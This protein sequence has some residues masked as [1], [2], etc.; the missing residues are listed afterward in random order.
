MAGQGSARV[1]LKEI[2]LSQVRN[3]QQAPQGVPAAVV[4]PARKGPAFVPRTFANMQQFEEVFGSLN[5]RGRLTNSNLYGPLA[6]NEW[7][8]SAQAGTYLRVL[9]VGDGN[10]ST[11]GGRVQDAGFIVGEK[12]VHVSEDGTLGKLS[13]N[14]FANIGENPV[15]GRTH[16]LGCFMKDAPGSSY[17]KDSG[18]ETQDAQASFVIDFNAK[19]NNT[20]PA[21]GSTITI[22]SLTNNQ[23][24][25]VEEGQTLVYGFNTTGA[26]AGSDHVVNTTVQDDSVKVAV[27]L[28]RLINSNHNTLA[29]VVVIQADGQDTAKISIKQDVA[30]ESGN[31]LITS[32]LVSNNLGDFEISGQEVITNSVNDASIRLKGG[33]VDSGSI[34]ISADVDEGNAVNN[35]NIKSNDTLILSAL[36]D[37]G[38]L[39]SGVTITFLNDDDFN[40]LDIEGVSPIPEDVF[41]KDDNDISLNVKIGENAADTVEGRKETLL[42]LATAINNETSTQ[43]SGLLSAVV[44][45]DGLTLTITQV[46]PGNVNNNPDLE[47]T[48]TFIFTANSFKLNDAKATGAE[49]NSG[50]FEG[51]TDGNASV[52]IVFSS[53]PVIGDNFTL[54]AKDD[55]SEKFEFIADANG[56]DNGVDGKGNSLDAI[57]V[58]LADTLAGTIANLQSA[59]VGA[60]S[61]S[62]V[63]DLFSV[64]DDGNSLTI[65]QTASGLGGNTELIF[66]LNEVVSAVAGGVTITGNFGNKETRFNGGGGS[67]SPIIRGVLMTP[68]GVRA[69]LSSDDNSTEPAENLF[70]AQELD[71]LSGDVAGLI[72]NQYSF[73]LFLNG[74]AGKRSISCSFDPDSSSYISK[75]LNT[76]PTKIEEEGHCLYAWWDIHSSVATPS[77]QGLTHLG[78]PLEATA[79]DNHIA[80]CVTGSEAVGKDYESFNARYQTART[81]W[82]MSQD[83]GGTQ[84]KLF[85]LHSLDDGEISNGM[86]RLLMSNL[87]YESDVVYGRFD[88][89]LE[90][91]STSP[92][93]GD[94]IVGW[95]NLS[96]DPD[97]RNYIARVIGD[98]YT[99]YNFDLEE[100]KQRL[101]VEGNYPIRNNFVRIELSDDLLS[102]NVPVDAL[103]TGFLGHRYLNTSIPGNFVDGKVFDDT[104]AISTAVVS[105]VKFVK[106]I[107]RKINNST[108]EASSDLAWGVKLAKKENDDDSLKELSE[109][110]NDDSIVSYTKYFPHFGDVFIEDDGSTADFQNGRFSLEKIQ[111]P[112]SGLSGDVLSSWDNA[113]YRRDGS[114]KGDQGRFVKISKDATGKNVRF[115]KFRCLFQGGF[116]GVNIF[117]KEKAEFTG[118]ASLREGGDETGTNKYTGPTVMAYRRACDVLTDKSAVEFQVLALPGQRASVVTDYALSACE[119]RFDA[120]Y[121][122]DIVE[123]DASLNVI[124]SNSIK[125]HVRNTVLE[126][127][128]RG[129]DSSFGAAYFPDVMVR[130]PSDGA[131]VSVPPSVGM[132][133]VLSRNDQISAPWFAPAGLN[134][135][136]LN[137]TGVKVQMNRDL[138]DELYDADINPIYEPA[139]RAGEVYAFGQKTLMQDSSALDRINVR[140]LLI[141][142]RRKVKR[143]GESLLFE[144]NRASTLARFSALVEPIMADVQSRQGVARYKVQID[145]STTTQNDIENNTIRGKIYLQPLKSIEFISLDFVVANTIE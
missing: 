105:P 53:L 18:V 77:Q 89:T 134:R 70:V 111:I 66:N 7:M 24:N 13:D 8:R 125:P 139:G 40:A 93:K 17:L 34:A 101:Q 67:A 37:D 106:S 92:Q 22:T 21:N 27:E 140:R 51:G 74:H 131:S 25:P 119:E 45:E 97:D 120:L 123:K 35:L 71:N 49:V 110:V 59:I 62:A 127:S 115:L 44:S 55:T 5:T 133:G 1:T 96:L 86:Y 103:P 58:E 9:G 85:R 99:Y 23:L 28:A 91:L 12:Q 11:G 143:I 61:G 38:D 41:F 47:A 87:R 63:K 56:V 121:L 69:T 54:V 81:P 108:N 138:L 135:G 76:D 73:T 126:F 82:I 36:K 52:T 144:P 68:Q 79:F 132:L 112:A 48:A 113:E 4:G 88:L 29:A 39:T 117:D 124:E 84:F 90:R 100:S 57:G 141:D 145:S 42:N 60:G 16:F 65:S 128:G 20:V 80:F 46:N 75:V 122:M 142:I 136:R 43:L 31:T 98:Q 72:G 6:L 102:G 137:S 26:Q 94:V 118:V 19:D 83:F 2:D 30:G 64:N 33:G 95:K 107:S 32:N 10:P 129:L 114:L 50:R 116:D 130:R 14:P 109:I 3:P 15:K 104:D 78:S